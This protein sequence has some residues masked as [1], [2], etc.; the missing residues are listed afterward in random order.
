MEQQL[1]ISSYVTIT[2]QQVAVNGELVFQ[3]DASVLSSFLKEAIRNLDVDYP[4][5]YKM[6][7][8][9]KLAFTAAEYLLANKPYEENTAVVLANRSG[10]LDTDV[11]HWNSIRDEANYYP[12]PAV[13]VYTLANICIGELCIRHR[14]I[15]ENAFFV[16]EAYD[17]LSQKNYAE[18]LLL[19]GKAAQVLC[20]WV[21]VFEDNYKAVL[22]TVAKSG[23]LPHTIEQ[24]D[25]L[26]IK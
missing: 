2:D 21:E 16:S 14:F 12:S 11:K 13:F 9:S 26:F 5:F 18:Y 6:D 24:I 22:Y 25:Q 17:S 15:S 8:L 1:Y 19:S 23:K 7:N 4:K 20:G 10:S 3:G